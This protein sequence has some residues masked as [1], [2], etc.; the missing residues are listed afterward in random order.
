MISQNHSE[1]ATIINNDYWKK[2]NE[3]K[4]RN[5]H[6]LLSWMKSMY[7]QFA[8]NAKQNF[9]WNLKSTK[10]TKN[11]SLVSNF[12]YYFFKHFFVHYYLTSMGTVEILFAILRLFYSFHLIRYIFIPHV[13]VHKHYKKKISSGKM[14]VITVLL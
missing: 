2:F 9:N 7:A 14:R 6:D 8:E 4:K 12:W 5:T 10:S 1:M 3:K 13:I 11:W